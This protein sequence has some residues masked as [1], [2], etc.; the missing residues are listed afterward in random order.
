M[1]TNNNNNKGRKWNGKWND[2]ILTTTTVAVILNVV[3]IFVAPALLS[4]FAMIAA[5]FALF[6]LLLMAYMKDAER[7]MLEKTA[8]E[9]VEEAMLNYRREKKM[10]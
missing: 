6:G 4:V 10:R 8:R 7:V 1:S 5:F 2:L 9:I 3:G